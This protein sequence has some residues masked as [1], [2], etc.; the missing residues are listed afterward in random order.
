MVVVST[1]DRGEESSSEEVAL[2]QFKTRLGVCRMGE[3]CGFAEFVTGWRVGDGKEILV[4]GV[5]LGVN[6]GATGFNRDPYT[7]SG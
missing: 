1:V 4:M 5:D 6:S 2:A 7:I 3:T